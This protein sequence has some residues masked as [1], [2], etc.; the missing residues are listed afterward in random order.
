MSVLLKPQQ[1]W[2]M[3]QWKVVLCPLH[4]CLSSLWT[5]T[6]ELSERSKRVLHL[7]YFL[8]TLSSDS[9][10][11]NNCLLFSILPQQWHL[12]LVPQPSAHHQQLSATCM[13]STASK[14]SIGPTRV[15]RGIMWSQYSSLS[16]R[17]DNL[18]TEVIFIPLPLQKF[19][20]SY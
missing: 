14:M 3:I 17:E 16:M 2:V 10:S 8:L 5:T 7:L 18:H 20:N 6:W 9:P 13:S 4:L 19:E 11:L 1:D 12:L 15:Y